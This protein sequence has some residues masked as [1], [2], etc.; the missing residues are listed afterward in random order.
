MVRF[1]GILLGVCLICV[2][3]PTLGAAPEDA[4][5]FRVLLGLTDTASTAWDGSLTVT[6]GT[7][8][9]LEPWRFEGEDRLQEPSAWKMST[10]PMRVFGG[11]AQAGQTQPI[12]ANGVIA[13]FR[14]LGSE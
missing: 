1:S 4:T 11:A 5:A 7:A 10:H 12:V 9:G 6:R 8:A 2:S 14:D 13:T 3:I